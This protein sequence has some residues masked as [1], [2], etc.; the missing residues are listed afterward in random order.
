MYCYSFRFPH[1]IS[2]KTGMPGEPGFE[3]RQPG[4]RAYI[5]TLHADLP[6]PLTPTPCISAFLGIRQIAV[7]RGRIYS[8]ERRLKKKKVET[9]V[10]LLKALVSGKPRPLAGPGTL[11]HE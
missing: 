9:E 11:A 3:P 5:L 6:L 7:A 4:S 2:E 10:G 8:L 1:I